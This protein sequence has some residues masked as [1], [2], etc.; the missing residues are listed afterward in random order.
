MCEI[1][2]R[3]RR[4]CTTEKRCV[5]LRAGSENP[6]GRK[7]LSAGHNNGCNARNGRRTNNANPSSRSIWERNENPMPSLRTAFRDN[8]LTDTQPRRGAPQRCRVPIA[9]SRLPPRRQ[10]QPVQLY[11]GS[12][13]PVSSR[14]GPAPTRLPRPRGAAC[15][16]HSN[17]QTRRSQ[18]ASHDNRSTYN[19]PQPNPC[20]NRCGTQDSSQPNPCGNNRCGAQNTPQ[21]NLC[22]NRRSTQDVQPQQNPC[23]DRRG[24]YNVPQPDP[25]NNRRGTQDVQPRQ[26]PCGNR[27]GTY[28]V[29]QTNC[30]GG[31]SRNGTFTMSGTIQL[32]DGVQGFVAQ[33][34]TS[35]QPPVPTC[36][37]QPAPACFQSPSNDNQGIDEFLDNQ[38]NFDTVAP[39]SLAVPGCPYVP[40][41]D[42][43]S[44]S[45]PENWQEL[46]DNRSSIG[47]QPLSMDNNFNVRN[48]SNVSGSNNCG[49]PSPNRDSRPFGLNDSFPMPSANNNNNYPTR[50]RSVDRAA[51][52]SRRPDFTVNDRRTH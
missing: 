42:S 6:G 7:C 15:R 49:C 5:R 48:D 43:G 51:V 33:G 11:L 30:G 8:N 20:S 10:D 21:S 40:V 25:C 38:R 17:G 34:S 16:N 46:L 29:T 9:C 12:R 44:S 39:R 37:Q 52:C 32:T 19:A 28:N 45:I 24:T 26:D 27:R 13:L 47:S 50:T 22:G 4:D 41:N 2:V 36:F 14:L 23:D 3:N 31:P 18:S 1:F 35:F